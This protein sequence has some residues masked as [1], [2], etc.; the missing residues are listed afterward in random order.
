VTG[1]APDLPP[2]FRLVRLDRVGSTNDEARRLAGEG[3][4]ELTLV[5]ALEQT[6]GRGR[7]GRAWA[8]PPGNL[9]CSLV[10]RPPVPVARAM[11]VSLVAAVAL[12]EAM[13]SLLPAA[14]A[15]RLKWPNDLLLDER[16]AAGIL[17]ESGLAADGSLDHLILGTGVNVAS[18]PEEARLPA[19]SLRACGGTA[20]VATV[21]AAYARAFAAWYAAWRAEGLA[22]VRAAWL[23]RAWRLGERLAMNLGDAVLA[24]RFVGLAPDGRLV[25]ALDD[26]TERS[27]AAGEAAAARAA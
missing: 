19:T 2:G 16:K 15:L 23:A 12:A 7:Q 5:W 26:G 24:G 25:L 18:H 21:L 20:D 1:R 6:G 17:L 3:A 11:E 8:S 4:P 22:P 10:L 14:A 13:A 27:L 9:Y